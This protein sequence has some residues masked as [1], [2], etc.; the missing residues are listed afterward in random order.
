MADETARDRV[1]TMRIINCFAS[2]GSSLSSW[3]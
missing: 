2:D 1:M 3:L